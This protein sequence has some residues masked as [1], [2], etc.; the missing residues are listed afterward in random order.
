[1][2]TVWEFT[3]LIH[4]TVT[5][6]NLSTKMQIKDSQKAQ[7][8]KEMYSTYISLIKGQS[9]QSF[10]WFDKN[11]VIVWVS[12]FHLI[13]KEILLKNTHLYPSLYLKVTYTTWLQYLP[14]LNL[15]T[16][17]FI[18]KVGAHSHGKT[19]M[20][21]FL[22][23]KK[24]HILYEILDTSLRKWFWSKARCQWFF[25]SSIVHLLDTDFV[26]CFHC[27]LLDLDCRG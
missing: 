15:C 2:S 19:M 6:M 26:L 9:P 22:C 12:W 8:Q 14:P 24:R 5:L 17:A 20:H 13:S 21:Q 16:I 7:V 1:M 27:V 10:T 4:S 18:Q 25:V 11:A 3:S 23:G